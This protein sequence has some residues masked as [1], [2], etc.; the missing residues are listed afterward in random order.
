[1]FSREQLNA[2]PREAALYVQHETDCPSAP[3]LALG[4]FECV[5]PNWLSDSLA[6]NRGTGRLRLLQGRV[7][8]TPE[9]LHHLTAIARRTASESKLSVALAAC[10]RNHSA[11]VVAAGWQ[12]PAAFWPRGALPGSVVTHSSVISAPSRLFAARRCLESGS[13]AASTF[14]SP[15]RVLRSHRRKQ[16]AV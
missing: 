4:N 5:G 1:M 13:A 12:A 2:S 6:A 8:L 11:R 9:L 14:L 3:V 7:R 15:P 16:P 10:A